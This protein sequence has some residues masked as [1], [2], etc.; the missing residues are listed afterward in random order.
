M[1]DLIGRL[2]VDLA[3]SR[4]IQADVGRGQGQPAAPLSLPLLFS[5]DRRA[6]P[7]RGQGEVNGRS[8]LF[9]PSPKVS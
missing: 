9:L 2:G 3:S 6:I 8:I 1:Q 7:S 5:K 4:E